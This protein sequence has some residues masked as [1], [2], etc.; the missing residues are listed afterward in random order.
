M[1]YESKDTVSEFKKALYNP[2]Q[3]YERLKNKYTQDVIE[4]LKSR[5]RTELGLD[6]DSKF[7]HSYNYHIWKLD[8]VI[9]EINEPLIKYINGLNKKEIKDIQID[10]KYMP[11]DLRPLLYEDNGNTTKR[12]SNYDIHIKDFLK[13]VNYIN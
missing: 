8:K 6:L 9:E 13:K 11:Y 12:D 5:V 2:L 3:K 10:P 7:T 4:K 1:N